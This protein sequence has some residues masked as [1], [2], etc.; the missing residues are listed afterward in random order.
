MRQLASF[1]QRR[2][3]SQKYSRSECCF[4]MGG[5]DHTSGSD[6]VLLKT[7]SELTKFFESKSDQLFGDIICDDIGLP[8]NTSG[9]EKVLVNFCLRAMTKIGQLIETESV[10]KK[11]VAGSGKEREG[12]VDGGEREG[13]VDGDEREGRG[14]GAEY[15]RPRGRSVERKRGRDRSRDD[16]WIT[17]GNSGIK[18]DICKLINRVTIL[19]SQV[20]ENSQRLRKG[21]VICNSPDMVGYKKVVNLLKP[22]MPKPK[23]WEGGVGEINQPTDCSTELQ[24]VLNLVER[25]YGVVVPPCEVAASH[26]LPNGSYILRFYNRNP[27]NSSWPK[28]VEAMKEGGDKDVNFFVNFNLTRQRLALLKEV[29]ARRKSKEIEKYNVDENGSITIRI[30]SRWLRLTHHYKDDGSVICSYTVNKVKDLFK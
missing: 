15:L 27:V 1:C 11:S 10:L 6:K 23:S 12:E 8:S 2:K 22:L 29:R 9:V 17:V 13:A 28:L 7:K 24:E 3:T 21:T 16:S 18:K 26:W 25:K 5:L 30:A 4:K 20:E 14:S 19:E